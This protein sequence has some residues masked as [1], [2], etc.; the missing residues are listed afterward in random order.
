M[1]KFL[2]V[3]EEMLCELGYD[4]SLACTDTNACPDHQEEIVTLPEECAGLFKE[5][6]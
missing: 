4:C 1:C 3:N 6:E 2:H 5:G